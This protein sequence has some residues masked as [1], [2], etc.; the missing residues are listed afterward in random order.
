MSDKTG[1]Q[2]YDERSGLIDDALCLRESSRVANAVRVNYFPFYEYGLSIADAMTDYDKATEAYMRYHREFQPDIGCSIASQYSAKVLEMFGVKCL[3]WPGDA[4][5][6]DKNAPVQ[7]VEYA[8]LMEDEYDEF[9]DDPAG[10]AVR[11]WLPRVFEVFEPLSKIDYV[12]AISGSYLAAP[13]IF[14]SPELLDSYRRLLAAAEEQQKFFAACGRCSA[15][16]TE[17]G[18]PSISG[19]GSATAFDMLGDSLRG[20]FGMMPDLLEQPE[21]VKRACELFVKLQIAQSVASYKRSGNRYQWVMLHK[22]FDNFI[23]D[24]TYA[25]FYWP[26]LRQWIM[27]LIDEGIVPVVF[28]EGAYNTR[29]KYLADVPKGKVIYLFEEIDIYEAK[30]TLGGTACIMGGFPEFTV[31][32]GTKEQIRDKVKEYMDVLAPGGGYIFSLSSSLD[33]CPREN[34]ETLFEAV[35]LYGKK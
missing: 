8:T 1:K 22:G 21:N 26:Y 18:F 9:F 33:L 35:E 23:G 11:K 24:E 14:T 6:L 20:T 30:K 34:L 3:R 12:A 29:L 16:L 2:L 5:G 10:F 28:C 31:S 27:A 19:G 13:N 32:H 25:E 15:M 7:F 17:E 4:K